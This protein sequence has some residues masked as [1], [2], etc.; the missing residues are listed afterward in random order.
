MIVGFREFEG[1]FSSRLEFCVGAVLVSPDG[2]QYECVKRSD[3]GTQWRIV[4]GQ[5]EDGH[6]SIARMRELVDDGAGWMIA[7]VIPDT[8]YIVVDADN[9]SLCVGGGQGAARARVFFSRERAEKAVKNM[10]A[11]SNTSSYRVIEYKMTER[12]M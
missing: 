6:V 8:V 1:Q 7:E 3:Y 5:G 11:W 12:N 9:G 10:D 2:V 4:G